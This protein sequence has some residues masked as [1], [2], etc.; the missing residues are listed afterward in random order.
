MRQAFDHFVREFHERWPV[1]YRRLFHVF[2]ARMR[3]GRRD[4]DADHHD[5]SRHHAVGDVAAA[6]E[7]GRRLRRR[8]HHE[9]R[10]SDRKRYTCRQSAEQPAERHQRGALV[11]VRTQFGRERRARNFV[12]SDRHAHENGGYEQI[13]EQGRRLPVR[14]VPQHE[15]E[16]RD[17]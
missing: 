15:V 17:R 4:Q 10:E 5:D 14:R 1:P 13:D 2:D 8:W 6:I 11:I 16:Q 12:A 9:E 3:S 7:D